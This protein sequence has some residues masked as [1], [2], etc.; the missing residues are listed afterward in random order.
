MMKQSIRWKSEEREEKSKKFSSGT[1]GLSSNLESSNS[2]VKLMQVTAMA[3]EN[4]VVRSKPK[5]DDR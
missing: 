4:E 2:P 3:A 1:G 5:V